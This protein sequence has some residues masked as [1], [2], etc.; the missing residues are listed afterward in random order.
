MNAPVPSTGRQAIRLPQGWL[1]LAV[2]GL[3]LA[4]LA[5]AAWQRQSAVVRKPGASVPEESRSPPSSSGSVVIDENAPPDASASLSAPSARSES[6][7]RR[8][9]S[10][11]TIR[12]E[13]GKVVFRGEVDVGPTLDRIQRGEQL[14][15]S[16]DGSTFQNRERRLP[17]QAAGY[18][19]EYVHPTQELSGPGPQRIVIGRRGEIYYTP[20]HYRS[21]QRLD[22]P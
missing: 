9:I 12:N 7:T 5:Y 8:L 22:K 18:Y 17:Q 14:N 15:F 16:H 3:L 21:F 2:T 13:D 1:R 11:L 4:L 20:D 6:A 10:N 19:K